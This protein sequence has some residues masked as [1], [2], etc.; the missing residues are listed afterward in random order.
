MYKEQKILAIIPARGGSKGILRKN[1]TPLG[2]KPLISYT[3]EAALKSKYIDRVIVST[4]DEEIAEV[5]KAYGAE[6]PF[7]RPQELATDTTPSITV[8]PHTLKMLEE[9]ENYHPDIVIYLELTYPFRRG[10]QID[11][12][13]EKI[14]DHNSVVSI[15]E[16]E[17]HPYL[18]LTQ[19]EKG[20]VH[21]YIKL[22]K[23]PFRRQ[24]YPSVLRLEGAFYIVRTD[25]YQKNPNKVSIFPDSDER[26]CGVL[27][28]K[29]SSIDVDEP[30]DLELAE[31]YLNHGY[32]NQ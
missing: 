5:S 9:Q 20:I 2:G 25:Y 17:D 16:V 10:K 13:L 7:R 11:D 31:Y 1:I 4:E 19:D 27:I 15:G 28:N 18:M 8:I 24:E 23:R 30:S 22:Q 32:T 14:D 29:I 26:A 21:P 6:V 12:A 3:I